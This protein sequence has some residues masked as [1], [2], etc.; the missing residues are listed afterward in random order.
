MSKNFGVIRFDS[1]L[2]FNQLNTKLNTKFD[3][4]E[5]IL[6]ICSLT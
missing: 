4:I 2:V 6:I 5:H 3:K 1:V